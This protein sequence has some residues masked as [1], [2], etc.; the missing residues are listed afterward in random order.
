LSPNI[1]KNHQ[2]IYKTAQNIDM[3]DEHNIDMW[4]EILDC[5]KRK[6]DIFI[7]KRNTQPKYGSHVDFRIFF[8]TS[9]LTTCK[10]RV[11]E[12]QMTSHILNCQ[13]SWTRHL[14]SPNVSRINQSISRINPK[15]QKKFM[16]IRNVNILDDHH[17]F[18]KQEFEL[19]QQLTNKIAKFGLYTLQKNGCCR[20]VKSQEHMLQ[21][22]S[23]F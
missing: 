9:E 21:K 2:K 3:L 7:N 12:S 19:K 5:L 10:H 15:D 22:K 17:I 20:R 14:N 1:P 11:V 6:R 23:Q 18:I 4:D 8:F 16:V 13:P